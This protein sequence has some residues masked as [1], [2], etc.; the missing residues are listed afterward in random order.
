MELQH[1]CGMTYKWTRGGTAV[2]LALLCLSVALIVGGCN[3]DIYQ[4]EFDG[5]IHA[6]APSLEKTMTTMEYL[7]SV[8]NAGSDGGLISILQCLSWLYILLVPLMH[9][10]SLMLL[11][12]V[13]LKGQVQRQIYLASEVA[14]LDC[15]LPLSCC[16]GAGSMVGSGS[17]HIV[18]ND[19]C[20]RNCHAS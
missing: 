18:C 1:E 11:W 20:P 17:I 15:G 4:L 13:P 19:R 3:A 7:S 5:L 8:D 16:T 10:T 9:L 6:I 14:M 2:L 12:T